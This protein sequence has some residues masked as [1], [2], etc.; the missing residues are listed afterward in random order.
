MNGQTIFINEEPETW[1]WQMIFPKSTKLVPGDAGW[2]PK[3]SDCKVQPLQK[4]T[5][6][7][8]PLMALMVSPF[9]RLKRGSCF[10][11]MVGADGP[12]RRLQLLT[13]TNHSEASV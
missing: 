10:V 1:R 5:L 13:P 2:K 9:L 7:S 3:H 4:A 6:L 12:S 8:D 11:S